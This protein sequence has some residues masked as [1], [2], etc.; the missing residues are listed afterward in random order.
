MSN[1]MFHKY[2]INTL[3][4]IVFFY[5]I[6]RKIL[7]VRISRIMYSLFRIVMR[8]LDRNVILRKEKG[9]FAF[10]PGAISAN[11]C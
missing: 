10:L 9:T 11:F 6:P 3:A 4:D 8:S 7:F 1:I 2:F 5:F